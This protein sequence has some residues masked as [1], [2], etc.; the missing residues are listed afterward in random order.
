VGG[1]IGS[2]L[3]LGITALAG[4]AFEDGLSVSPAA[5]LLAAGFAVLIG[6]SA[7]VYPALKA[8]RLAPVDALRSL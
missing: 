1:L 8:A 3:G 4:Q 5:L 7:G 6:L 2:V